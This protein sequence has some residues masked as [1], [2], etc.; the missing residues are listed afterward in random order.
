MYLSQIV[1]NPIICSFPPFP[2]IPV[3]SIL[4]VQGGAGSDYG[5]FIE[6]TED[7]TLTGF[8]VFYPNQKVDQEPGPY[9]W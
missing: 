5:C 9:P 3:G 8:S 7:S 6:L 4:N 2:I 1:I